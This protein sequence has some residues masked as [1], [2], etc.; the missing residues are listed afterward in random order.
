MLRKVSGQTGVTSPS[1]QTGVTSPSA[2]TGVTSPSGQTGVTSPSGEYIRT[3]RTVPGDVQ[4]Y[5]RSLSGCL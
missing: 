2:Q 4:V 3:F 1:A 5:E